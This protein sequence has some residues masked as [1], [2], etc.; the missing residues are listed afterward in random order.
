[1]T[2]IAGEDLTVP[3]DANM[4]DLRKEAYALLGIEENQELRSKLK[5]I[6][7]RYA[8]VINRNTLNAILR[9]ME[10]MKEAHRAREKSLMD[11]IRKLKKGA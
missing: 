4:G 2:L 1:M 8:V 9:D 3:L 10:Q 7:G 11:E 6:F 5:S